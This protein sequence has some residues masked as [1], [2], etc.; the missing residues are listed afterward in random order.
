[1]QLRS[2]VNLGLPLYIDLRRV[3]YIDES[4]TLASQVKQVFYVTD[5][6]N[7]QLS[8]VL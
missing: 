2:T 4:F 3:P 7:P 8:I 6:A 1:M 5:I